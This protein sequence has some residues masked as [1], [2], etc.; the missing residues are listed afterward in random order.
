[1]A[2]VI[3]GT[4]KAKLTIDGKEWDL[5]MKQAVEKTKE[6]DTASINLAS[7]IY[8]VETAFGYAKTAATMYTD[9]MT[10]QYEEVK[11]FNQ[12]TGMSLEQGGKWQDMMENMGY[13]LSDMTTVIRIFSNNIQQTLADPDSQA[14]KGFKQLGV[15]L[16]D[17]QGNI[18][19]TNSVLLETLSALQQM[20]DSM[21]K[22]ALAVDL[23]GRQAMS[24]QKLYAAGGDVIKEYGTAVSNVSEEGKLKAEA[25]EKAM[26]KFNNE[27]GDTKAQI[28][29]GLIPMFTQL[30]TLLNTYVL[31]AI[32][33]I[34]NR[35]MYMGYVVAG[36]GSVTA[37]KS[38]LSD[39]MNYESFEKTFLTKKPTS[40]VIPTPTKAQT[41]S[42]ASE[43]A[44]TGS[45]ANT[46]K[47]TIDAEFKAA[48]ESVQIWATSMDTKLQKGEDFTQDYLKLVEAMNEAEKLNALT[49]N[50]ELQKIWKNT[51][52]FIETNGIKGSMDITLYLSKLNE[53]GQ[54]ALGSGKE[55]QWNYGS[56]PS[57]EE[58]MGSHMYQYMKWAQSVGMTQQEALDSWQSG[59]YMGPYSGGNPGLAKYPQFPGY[60][61]YEGKG[62]GLGGPVMR[63]SPYIV[64]ERGP[65]IFVPGASG[66]IIP[67]GAVMHVHVDIDGNEIGSAMVDLIRLKTGARM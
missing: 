19:D 27:L 24:I 14:A 48:L 61:E 58:P 11:R 51:K 32:N 57:K 8:L 13:T 45:G 49:T 54:P 4:L 33:E 28:G 15:Q 42:D 31:P 50:K 55:G 10:S 65:E 53:T 44:G 40:G 62:M 21:S 12:M 30:V 36:L 64:G 9:A 5:T 63:G 26:N 34:G 20:P 46:A 17:T 37:G 2:D 18:R 29:E 59:E 23:L 67:N 22:S 35:L 41:I 16:V 7:Q 47:G 56:G 66:N 3:V 52:T 60:D 6:L 38:Q 25:W 39:I 43:K 1:M